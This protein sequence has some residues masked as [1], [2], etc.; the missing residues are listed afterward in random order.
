MRVKWL[1]R[2]ELHWRSISLGGDAPT[3]DLIVGPLI[4]A[5]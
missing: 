3:D 5:E 1:A 2:R 4:A